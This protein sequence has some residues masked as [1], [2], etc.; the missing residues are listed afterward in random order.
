MK[1]ILLVLLSSLALDSAFAVHEKEYGGEKGNGGDAIVCLNADYTVASVEFL[2]LFETR[3]IHGLRPDLGEPGLSLE[4]K[5]KLLTDHIGR[6]FPN[7][8][9]RFAE[10]ARTF[11][12]RAVFVDGPLVDIPDTGEII[13]P[14]S[15]RIEQAII[16]GPIPNVPE[17]SY[18]INTKLWDKMDSASKVAAIAHEFFYGIGVDLFRK[19][20][21]VEARRLNAQF[22]GNPAPTA[23]EWYEWTRFLR[24][25]GFSFDESWGGGSGQ[26]QQDSNGRVSYASTARTRLSVVSTRFG[27]VRIEEKSPYKLVFDPKTQRSWISGRIVD[28]LKIEFGGKEWELRRGVIDETQD[29]SIRIVADEIVL[30]RL[31][32][33]SLEF[34]FSPE[35]QSFS[36]EVSVRS[37]Y[38][39]LA[40]V[41]SLQSGCVVAVR[42]GDLWS[43]ELPA[44]WSYSTQGMEGR[45]DDFDISSRVRNF[46]T[47]FGTYPGP[48]GKVWIHHEKGVTQFSA[49]H[50]IGRVESFRKGEFEIRPVPMRKMVLPADNSL[51][52]FELARAPV[53][54]TLRKGLEVS[55]NVESTYFW[56]PKT[57]E[58]EFKLEGKM[59]IARMDGFAADWIG[60]E[61]ERAE[62][63]TWDPNRPRIDLGLRTFP[64]AKWN[65][66]TGVESR[67]HKITVDGKP[68]TLDQVYQFGM[69]LET[70]PLS[71]DGV[72]RILGDQGKN[73]IRPFVYIPAVLSDIRFYTTFQ[74]FLY[75]GR[76]V[77]FEDR[78]RGPRTRYG[79]PLY[80]LTYD[81]DLTPEGLL[82]SNVY[83]KKGEF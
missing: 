29:D 79:T 3:E 81:V 83:L 77:I 39:D 26:I 5:T 27:T 30:P 24:D 57:D 61:V 54:I 12:D 20:N 72:L 32:Q 53:K 45:V 52:G 36:G 14:K 37:A 76:S 18:L 73:S 13:L 31:G 60:V 16:R 11:V 56:E 65:P 75:Y 43:T 71:K 7:L 59:K 21:S 6:L 66:K 2:D 35:C 64:K 47:R 63:A 80:E 78:R 82:F 23:N 49:S 10:H 28:P 74:G 42:S 48:E 67:F 70:L 41:V 4:E 9:R 62:S 19:E 8:A 51:A 69:D 55:G 50:E 25:L 1:S 46:R 38:F 22:L 34:S 58:L 33:K 15:C 68:A 40:R 17:K 44:G